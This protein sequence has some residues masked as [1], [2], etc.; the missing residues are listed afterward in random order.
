MLGSVPGPGSKALK[1]ARKMRSTC[2]NKQNILCRDECYTENNAGGF[3]R[4]SLGCLTGVVS[5]GLSEEVT[6]ELRPGQEGDGRTDQ[7]AQLC[8]AE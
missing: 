6:F 5:S 4:E 3:E 7:Q 2:R 1:K 8:Q